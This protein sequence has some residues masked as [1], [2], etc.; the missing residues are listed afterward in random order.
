MCLSLNFGCKDSSS[1]VVA[2]S[3][4]M[5]PQISALTEEIDKNPE[6]LHFCLTELQG[7]MSSKLRPYYIGFKKKPFIWILWTQF[8][9][10]YFRMFT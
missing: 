7:I 1:Q 9:T 6:N 3:G 8:I 10:I 4:Q 2:E 5:D